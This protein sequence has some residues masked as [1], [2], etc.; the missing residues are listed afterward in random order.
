MT[1]NEILNE[2]KIE[3][4]RFKSLLVEMGYTNDITL[5]RFYCNEMRKCS[6]RIVKLRNQYDDLFDKERNKIKRKELF[7][8]L[9]KL[10]LGGS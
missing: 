1:K 8:N 4:E 5:G 2:I 7:K 10:L 3:R 6:E 9:V